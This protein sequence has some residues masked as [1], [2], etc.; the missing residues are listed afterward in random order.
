ME[1]KRQTKK[2]RKREERDTKSCEPSCNICSTIKNIFLGT[3]NLLNAALECNTR[4]FIYVSTVDVVIGDDPIY[5]GAENTTPIPKSFVM[6]GY[7][8]TK[9][10][11]ELLVI[12]YNKRPLSDGSGSL[13]T[14]ILRPSLLYGE[15]DPHFVTQTLRLTK[16]M[17]GKLLRIDNIFTRCQVSYVGNAAWA[18]IKAKERIQVDDSIGGEEFYITDDTPILDPYDFLK[19]FL[20]IHGMTVSSWSVP[21]WLVLLLLTLVHFFVDLFKPIYHI[22][23]PA[24]F[25]IKKIKYICNTYFFNRNKAILR[26]DYDPLFTPEESQTRANEYYKTCQI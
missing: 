17:G 24:T 23:L 18:C 3:S 11:A 7:A 10:E 8:K 26:L 14:L 4:Y 22:K 1:K 12:S 16:K 5:F 25:D 9:R 21:F 15:G 13:R 2:V 6:G 19:P 20:S